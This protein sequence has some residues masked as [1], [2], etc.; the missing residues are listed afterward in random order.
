MWENIRESPASG[1]LSATASC[2]LKDFI[3]S[4][5][6]KWCHVRFSLNSLLDQWG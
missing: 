1:G 4:I 5:G 6:Q 2:A 3:S